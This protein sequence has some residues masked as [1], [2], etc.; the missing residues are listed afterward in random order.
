MYSA[1]Y[2]NDALREKTIGNLC[3]WREEK[4]CKPE[5]TSV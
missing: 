2:G 1:L 3:A 4:R 5:L